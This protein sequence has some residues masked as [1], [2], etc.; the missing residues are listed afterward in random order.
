[1]GYEEPEIVKV[2]GFIPC[3]VSKGYDL[4]SGDFVQAVDGHRA[5]LRNVVELLVGTQN[6]LLLDGKEHG[7]RNGDVHVDRIRIWEWALIAKI[8]CVAV[9]MALPVFPIKGET[10]PGCL[11]CML[12]D[13]FQPISN[14]CE[15]RGPSKGEV[16]I[17]RE[18]VIAEVAAFEGGAAFEDK[19]FSELALTQSN[20]KPCQTVIPL[21]HG[22]R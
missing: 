22:F 14:L 4:L 19:K 15:I 1:V 21:Q 9:D 11:G 12:V 17:F 18:A 6:L 16:Q 5:A 13:L 10:H 20:Q 2:A 8:E 7:F 3:P